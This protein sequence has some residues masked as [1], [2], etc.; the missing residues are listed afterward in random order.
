MGTFYGGVTYFSPMGERFTT[1]TSDRQLLSGSVVS[2]FCEAAGK[3]WIAT[4][5][6]GLSCFDMRRND[7]T[8]YPGQEALTNI[9]AHGLWAEG[10]DLWIG[11][12]GNGLIRLNTATGATKTYAIDG[13]HS[14]ALAVVL[15]NPE[16]VDFCA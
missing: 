16:T 1:F 10:S 3:V 4:D 12:Y 6:G 7:F 5:D 14:V 8:T 15:G 9:N 2:R 13:I 11:T